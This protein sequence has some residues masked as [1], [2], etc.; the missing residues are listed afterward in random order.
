MKSWSLRPALWSKSCNLSQ[1]ACVVWQAKADGV[2]A[3]TIA[4][5]LHSQVALAAQ[6]SAA[7]LSAANNIYGITPQ[8]VQQ[9]QGKM[10]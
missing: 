1:Q 3:N 9:A 6:L 10:E 5:E 7:Q 2:S 4:T 8:N